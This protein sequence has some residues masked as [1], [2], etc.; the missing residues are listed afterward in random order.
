MAV[1]LGPLGFPKLANA[2]AFAQFPVE[3]PPPKRSRMGGDGGCVY[4]SLGASMD[5]DDD[6]EYRSLDADMPEGDLM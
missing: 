6:D 4:C 3:V 2:T 1:P 5:V